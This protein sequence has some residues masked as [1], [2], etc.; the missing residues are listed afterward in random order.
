M[1]DILKTLTEAGL[2]FTPDNKM[3]EELQPLVE[4]QEDVFQDETEEETD[5]V[6]QEQTQSKEEN[7][8][9]EPELE[10]EKAEI[11]SFKFNK[12]QE[13]EVGESSPAEL[14]EQAVLSFLSERLG[15]QLNSIEDLTAQQEL[16]DP[17]IEALMRFKKDTGRG[18]NDYMTYQSLDTSKIDDLSAIRLKYQME[19]P[20]LTAEEREMLIADQYKIDE[21]EYT[22]REVTLGKAR[23]KADAAKA[24]REI[25]GLRGDYIV[26][27]KPTATAEEQDDVFDQS[28]MQEMEKSVSNLEALEF[29]VDKDSSFTFAVS[30]QYRN[31]LKN[32]NKNIESYFEQYRTKDGKWNHDLFNA[33]RSVV[34]NIDAIAREL[35]QQGKSDGQKLLLTE[36]ANA[37][38]KTT[39]TASTKEQAHVNSVLELFSPKN[40]NVRITNI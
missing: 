4:E 37:K 35:Y 27:Q 13:T 34:E 21:D 36:T 17:E 28:W 39:S 24:K 40:R 11:R 33:H 3:T 7:E 12:Q 38:T 31:N 22:E 15:K 25:E 32:Q 5:V 8:T 9:Q 23:L 29:E 14:N 26:R 19:N 10:R 30:D 16:N 1:N 2:E 18:L 20:D 6:E